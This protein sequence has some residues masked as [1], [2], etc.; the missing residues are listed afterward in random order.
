ML[1]EESTNVVANARELI[2]RIA[3]LESNVRTIEQEVRLFQQKGVS[4]KAGG[5][6][7][8]N[9]NELRRQIENQ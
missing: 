8:K 7:I 2:E 5:Q 9:I 1:Q 6:D 3:G 4:N